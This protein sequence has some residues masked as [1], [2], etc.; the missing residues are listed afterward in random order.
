MR[1]DDS[2][3][4]NRL[5]KAISVILFLL[6]FFSLAQIELVPIER[7]PPVEKKG[8]ANGRISSTPLAAMK[9]P[10]WDDFSFN[11]NSSTNL[12]FPNDTL[13][14]NSQ[15]VW[16]N[17][18][19]GINPPSVY[20]ATFDGYDSLGRPYTSVEL[21]RGFSDRMT[22]RGLRMDLIGA[23]QR[24]STFI[25]FFYQFQGNG[26]APDPGDVLNLYFK[27]KD[28]IWNLVWSIDNNGNL[29]KNQFVQV[30]VA[31]K[32][33]RYFHNN[34]QFRFQN[35]GR[36]SGPYDTWN[37]DYVYVSNGNHNL[38]N[39]PFPDRTISKN[40]TPL[41]GAYSAI[42]YKHL[43]TSP[44]EIV[45]SSF[46]LY[47]LRAGNVQP[48]NF[49]SLLTRTSFYHKNISG[50]F[51]PTF[52]ESTTSQL[53]NAVDAGS[54]SSLERKTVSLVNKP[55]L[56]GADPLTDSMIF[57]LKVSIN[58]KDNQTPSNNG[59]YTSA[60][61]NPIDFRRNDTIRNSFYSSSYYAYDDG[62][63]EYG[64][65][66]NGFGTQLAYE[67]DMKTTATDTIV[68][69]DT[70]FP[71]FGDESSQSIQLHVLSGLSENESDY[72]VR[73]TVQIKRTSRD[74]LKR[75]FLST[76]AV[77]QGK[78]YIGWKLLTSAI[79]PI[80]LDRNTDSGSKIY[81]NTTG[82]WVQNTTLKGSLMIHPVFIRK[83]EPPPNTAV[84]DEN[85]AK[86]YPNPSSGTFFLPKDAQ[87][88]LVYDTTGKPIVFD[89]E[90]NFDTLQV[91]LSS[92]S[93]FGF[94]MYIVRYYVLG[95]LHTEKLIIKP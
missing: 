72:L 83:G 50:K 37:I 29:D 43:K 54:V 86:L 63:A 55:S 19:M 7:T 8:N 16:V 21:A 64:A 14:E 2:I 18:V 80:G 82:T 36:L 47:N 31:I 73:Q 28:G 9:L 39:N 1:C 70:Y 5:L 57:K 92:V 81:V 41:F 77:V 74:S 11:A 60:I 38:A 13:W 71:K 59:D 58:T 93:S 42:P 79:I 56:L 32:D 23:A 17:D 90:E 65:K 69:I 4:S 26:E 87:R 67:F 25:N 49:S 76:P 24:P 48:I 44:S 40:L 20:V 95:K 88:I 33:D 27:D 62:V 3:I 34:F 22:S 46:D 61:F 89:L 78:F 12:Y 94:G 85:L 51:V 45:S 35:F 91:T 68:A 52:I 53:D 75:V 66:I 15:R 6:P 10:F 84:P 30:Q